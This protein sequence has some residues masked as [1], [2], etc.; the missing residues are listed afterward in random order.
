[1]VSFLLV[2]MVLQCNGSGN[3]SEP[4]QVPRPSPPEYESV[5]GDRP[6]TPSPT[7]VLPGHETPDVAFRSATPWSSVV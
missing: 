5:T 2:G 6:L 3:L 1:M 7:Q 4:D